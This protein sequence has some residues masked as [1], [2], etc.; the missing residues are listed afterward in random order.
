MVLQDMA[1]CTSA[2]N[3][4]T[5]K[6]DA[7]SP[8]LSEVLEVS[9]VPAAVLPSSGLSLM[10][11]LAKQGSID[12]VLLRKYYDLWNACDICSTVC[13]DT[14]VKHTYHD[15]MKLL[16]EHW[17]IISHYVAEHLQPNAPTDQFTSTLTEFAEFHRA[18]SSV[19]SGSSSDQN[20]FYL[21]LW[22][23]MEYL[24]KLG[25][26]TK[27]KPLRDWSDLFHQ[28]DDAVDGS[29]REWLLEQLDGKKEQLLKCPK[30]KRKI[31]PIF[32]P[33]DLTLSAENKEDLMKV[34]APPVPVSAI[35]P[36]AWGVR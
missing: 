19:P 5:M 28:Y 31:D 29:Y 22:E 11:M 20:R 9:I 15:S 1:Q 25:N 17:A 14:E 12:E 7:S 16:L 6:N 3:T 24:N 30:K 8:N 2:S 26:S 18:N 21:D 27:L 10:R 34:V 13:E 33:Y 35:H 36:A 23:E 4:I 32:V